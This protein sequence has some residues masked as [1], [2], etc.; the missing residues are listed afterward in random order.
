MIN[1]IIKEGKMEFKDIPSYSTYTRI[2]SSYSNT[3]RTLIMTLEEYSPDTTENQARLFKALLIQGS[4][5]SGYTYREFEDELKQHFAPYRYEESIIGGKVK[6]RKKVSEMTNR[7]FNIYLEQSIQF[8]AEF[9]DIK[10]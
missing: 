9:Y 5:A 10:F 3:G 1:V 2:L 7:E 8:C 6:I 4:N